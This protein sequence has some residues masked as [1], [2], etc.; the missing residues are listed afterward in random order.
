LANFHETGVKRVID[1][2]R[3]LYGIRKDGKPVPLELS[4][5]EIRDPNGGKS[6]FVGFARDTSDD[7]ALDAATALGQVIRDVSI[8][9]LMEMNP[10]GTILH[11]NDAFVREFRFTSKDQ[12]I[13]Q[14]VTIVATEGLTPAIH[15]RYVASHLQ[16]RGKGIVNS[17]RRVPAK[18]AD[19]TLLTVELALSEFKSEETG[20]HFFVSYLQN[21]EDQIELEQANST[22]NAITN[23]SSTPIIA[24]DGA[25]TVITFNEA[26]TIAFGYDADEVRGQNV[27]MLMPKE[28]AEKHDGYLRTYAKTG[29]RNVIDQVI[30]QQGRRKDGSLFP[31]ELRVKELNPAATAGGGSDGSK[32]D[33]PAAAGTTNAS[34]KLFVGYARDVTADLELER[35]SNI[36]GI[37]LS[38]SSTPILVINR[39]GKVQS[40]NRAGLEVFQYEEADV[41]GK[42]IKMLMPKRIAVHHDR[43]LKAYIATGEKRVIDST[44]RVEAKK[45]DGSEFACE[46]SVREVIP[47]SGNEEETVYAGFLR[48][49]TEEIRVER[50][51]LINRAVSDLSLYPLIVM[52]GEGV[53]QGYSSS[54]ASCFGFSTDEVVGQNI[55][56]LM[57]QETADKHDGYLAAFRGRPDMASVN[58]K[59]TVRARRKDGQE[60]LAR[61][62]V[63]ALSVNDGVK[64]TDD[65][66]LVGYLE[67]ITD[68]ETYERDVRI[69]AMA[70]SR[71]SVPV[72]EMEVDGTIKTFNTAAE[73]QFE[74]TAKDVVGNNI[75]MLMPEY[76]AVNHDGYLKRYLETGVKSVI[77]TRRS[78]PAMRK[79]GKEF[80][81]IISVFEINTAASHHYIGYVED[82]TQIMALA[83]ARAINTAALVGS[84][85]PFVTMDEIGTV[86]DGNPAVEKLFGWKLDELRG[87]NVKVLMAEPH[88]SRHD[89]YLARYRETGK[90]TVLNSTTRGLKAERRDGT[91][92]I[93]DLQVREV[94]LQGQRVFIGSFRETKRQLRKEL[95]R[96]VAVVAEKGCLRPIIAMDDVGTIL[97]MNEAAVVIFGYAH[98]DELLGKNIKVLQP[99]EVADKHDWYLRRYKQSGEKH[100]I[101]T[102]RQ[103]TGK[104]K[105]GSMVEIRL[106]VKE[107][108]VD[109]A[110]DNAEI[111]F[112]LM[113]GDATSKD[114]GTQT[115]YV[116][117]LEDVA[118]SNMMQ[119]G[120]VLNDAVMQLLPSPVVTIDERGTILSFNAA[121][122][123]TFEFTAK[124]VNGRNVNILMPHDVAIKHDGFLK[125]YS[126]TGVKHV[127]DSSRDVVGETKSGEPIH[128]TLQVREV[129]RP[130]KSGA[131]G[132][133][134][135]SSNAG[136]G[137]N[138]NAATGRRHADGDE[139]DDGMESIFVGFMKIHPR[140]Q[141]GM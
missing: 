126:D 19:G 63:R 48:D 26:A 55:K 98:P 10:D 7:G 36:F 84:N 106:E 51:T 21:V 12:L 137:M 1:T 70:I 112:S 67:D 79:G 71:A 103:V 47:T 133:G 9:P 95:D 41:V 53:I 44:R 29:L 8:V 134:R 136:G 52:T 99:R 102:K 13:G 80:P 109:T 16:G 39:V 65:V 58:V 24:M 131:G 91:T 75:K 108:T 15:D 120:G 5:R 57:P 81:A 101:D 86:M 87:E 132:G 100:V 56:M 107:V 113:H 6:S 32:D 61:I 114:I 111:D 40:I 28:I 90:A 110:A 119:L 96:A 18:R 82:Q 46:I 78:I 121:A 74:W 124:Q 138:T 37:V 45:K 30:R 43:F 38:L 60:F 4:V 104:K 116:A 50:R 72:I 141:P 77:G 97:R 25:G 123:T 66:M 128:I 11:V 83:E 125:R 92:T 20:R 42:N 2:T 89:G 129:R 59:R 62:Y 93:V 85:D 33:A 76:I 115:L 88:K 130:R 127:I 69:T 3:R 27:K 68:R 23:M 105:N 140:K 22:V 94:Q 17:T 14:N 135:P 118:Q 31:L 139:E 64:A 122:E 34:S 73:H 54:A 35:E 117:I 49:L